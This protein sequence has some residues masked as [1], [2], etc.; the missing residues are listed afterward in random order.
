MAVVRWH[1][2][3]ELTDMRRD[4]DRLFSEFFESRH[5]HRGW[6]PRASETLAGAPS[7]ELLDRKNQVVLRAEL[8]GV[9][10]EEVD[11]S[12]QDNT[13]TLKGEFKKEAK[14]K[15]E[16]YYFSERR[17]GKFRRTVSLP[18]EVVADKAK[19]TFMDGVLEVVFPK[20]KETRPREVKLE[21]S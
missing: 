9:K 14:V 4:M 1:P 11:I 21:V 19:A 12:V 2:L 10:K 7:L 16:D 17:Y 13:I 5:R 6:L 15:E 18:T 3:R 8:P 20:K